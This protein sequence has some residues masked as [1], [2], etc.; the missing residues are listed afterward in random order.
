MILKASKANT[1]K[2]SPTGLGSGNPS[3]RSPATYEKKEPFLTNHPKP[4]K[5]IRSS[6]DNHQQAQPEQ[7]RK[8]GIL[9]T[10]TIT[11]KKGGAERTSFPRHE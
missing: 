10:S 3:T 6:G 9:R 1:T 11:G 7:T 8:T 4:S 5:E 2:G